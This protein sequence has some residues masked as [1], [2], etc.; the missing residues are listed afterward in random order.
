MLTIL[1]FIIILGSLV[2]V[3]EFGHFIVARRNGIK[4]DEFG[5]GFPPRFVGVVKNDTTGKYDIIW[6]NRD[7]ASPHT[8]YSFNWIPLGGFVKIKGEEGGQTTD[9]DSFA[10]KPAWTRIKVL[11]A[12]VAMNFLLAWVLISLVYI[13][14]LPQPISPDQRG[15]Y[16]DQKVQILEVKPGTPAADMHL[17]P[18]D[19]IISIDGKTVVTTE[20][21]TSAIAAKKGQEFSLVIKRGESVMTLQGVPRTEYPKNEGALGISLSETALM[22]YPWYEAIVE[23]GKTTVKVTETIL[24]YLGKMLASLVGGAEKVALD[25]TGPVGIVY[26]TKQMTEMG[27]SYLLWFAALLSINLGIFNILPIPALDGGRIFFILI[28]KIKGK[29]V[30][31]FIENR[32]HQV[33]FMLLLFL[34]LL[35]TI[36]DF[37]QFQILDKLKGLFI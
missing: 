23:G 13:L 4:A 29:P 30:S 18:L 8:I 28:E 34:M 35:V 17:R 19:E 32:I 21:V 6:G 3:H 24:V 16:P 36:R 1:I 25:V 5:F 20:E 27:F 10:N 14:G 22:R 31:R 9:T 37:S 33:G 12:G 15:K 2:F 26:L 7:I 11:G